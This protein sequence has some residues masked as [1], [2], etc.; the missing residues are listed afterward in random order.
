MFNKLLLIV[1]KNFELF[2]FPIFGFTL[3]IWLPVGKLVGWL[4]GGW[5]VRSFIYCVICLLICF[6]WLF[7]YLFDDWFIYW[8]ADCAI[9]HFFTSSRTLSWFLVMKLLK[10]L[11]NR[12]NINCSYCPTSVP[13]VRYSFH[14][15]SVILYFCFILEWF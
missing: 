7:V 11:M 8:L 9:F 14:A 15:N 1:R 12:F 3:L 6:F 5:F 2:K 13:F 4:V 10:R